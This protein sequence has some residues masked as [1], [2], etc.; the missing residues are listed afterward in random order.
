[1]RRLI[2]GVIVSAAL[3]G[4]TERIYTW[5]LHQAKFICSHYDGIDHFVTSPFGN[6]VVCV[7]SGHPKR[8]QADST[9]GE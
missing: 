5:E 2:L 8:L 9:P 6:Y 7:A 4:C 1:M 3:T